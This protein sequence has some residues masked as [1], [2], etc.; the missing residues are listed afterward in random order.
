MRIELRGLLSSAQRVAEPGE[1]PR[2]AAYMKEWD[3]VQRGRG[4]QATSVRKQSCV[5]GEKK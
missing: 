5:R 3:V 1:G 2:R 4:F